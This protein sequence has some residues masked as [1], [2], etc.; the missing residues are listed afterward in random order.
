MFAF[1]RC[2]EFMNLTIMLRERTAKK[3]LFIYHII[4]IQTAPHF[5]KRVKLNMVM[6]TRRWRWRWRWQ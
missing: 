4:F 5:I 2:T 1:E 6:V 3:F